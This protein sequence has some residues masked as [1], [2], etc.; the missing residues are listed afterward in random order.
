PEGTPPHTLLEYFPDDYLLFIDESHVTV[1]QLGG[2]YRGDRSRKQTLVEFGF[3][4]PSARDNRPLQFSEFLQRIGQRLFVSATPGEY[5]IEQSKGNVVEQLVR[6]T[7]LMDPDVT[8]LPAEGQ[9]KALMGEIRTTVEARERVL[10][11]TLTKRMAEDLTGFFRDAGIRVRYLHSDIDTIER[12]EIIRDL[13]KGVFDVLV[14]INLLREGLDLPE[15]SLVAILDADKEGFLRSARS[16]IQTIGRAARNV[17][18]RVLLFADKTTNSIARAIEETTRRRRKQGEYNELHGITPATIKKSIGDVLS[19]IYEA[20]Y[21]TVNVESPAE[22]GGVRNPDQLRKRIES[23]R[24]KMRDA[25]SR[26]EYEKAAKFRDD[27][28]ALEEIELDL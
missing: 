17:R 18:G 24:R 7:G 6:P 28:F 26:M 14:G 16:L 13:R 1:P 27:L 3:R 20:D 12:T 9:V 10:V 23:L 22:R 2:M 25:A 4:L 19:S 21:V 11:T 15:V 5:E 8:I